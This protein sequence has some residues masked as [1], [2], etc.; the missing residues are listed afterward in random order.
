[1]KIACGELWPRRSAAVL[2]WGHIAGR[3]GSNAPLARPFLICLRGVRPFAVDTHDIEHAPE[4]D[5]SGVLLYPGDAP[6]VFPMASHA[7]QARSRLSPDVD[8]DGLGDVGSIRPGRYVLQDL[9]DAECIF[10]VR[11]PDGSDRI[12]C[13]RDFD[14]NRFISL[15]EVGRSESLRSGA[16]VGAA[17]TWADSI[18]LHGGLDSPP[19]AKHRSSIGCLTANLAAREL[20]RLRARAHAGTIDL[21]LENAWDVLPFAKEARELYDDEDTVPDIGNA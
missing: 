21:A 17:G 15:D 5:D 8:R 13:W 7:Y 3:I 9:G 20:L 4:Y 10:S 19:S 11:M 14:G 16:Q 1:M 12:P 2:H 18:L 6:I